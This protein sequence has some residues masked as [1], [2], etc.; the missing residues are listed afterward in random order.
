MSTRVVCISRSLAA[1][2]ELVASLVA[3]QL[4]FRCVDDEIVARAAEMEDLDPAVIEDVEKRK[5]LVARLIESLGS[6]PPLEAMS[7]GGMLVDPSLYLPAREAAQNIHR[8]ALPE[9]CRDLIRAATVEFA[10]EG[11]VVIIAHAAAMTLAGMDGVL[12]VWITASPEVRAQRLAAASAITVDAAAR[13]VKESDRARRDY[14]KRFHQIGEEG[15]SHYDLVLNT[16]HLSLE[17][18][19]AAIVAAAGKPTNV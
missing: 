1:G 15:P 4:G 6:G 7:L 16:E 5:S 9:R 11:G 13:E 14:I 2:G 8:A 3:E 17:R 18:C 10:R 12:R 19:A